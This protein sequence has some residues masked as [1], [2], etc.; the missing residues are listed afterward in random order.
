MSEF[1]MSTNYVHR[2]FKLPTSHFNHHWPNIRNHFNHSPGVPKSKK[3]NQKNIV[4]ATC[5][6]EL[7]KAF[8]CLAFTW[9]ELGTLFSAEKRNEM[10]PML[11]YRWYL[12]M[13]QKSH[14]QSPVGCIKTIMTHSNSTNLLGQQPSDSKKRHSK[15]M[16]NPYDSYPPAPSSSNF[17]VALVKSQLSGS[18]NCRCNSSAWPAAGIWAQGRFRKTIHKFHKRHFLLKGK[19]WNKYGPWPPTCFFVD[20]LAIK[21]VILKR[22]VVFLIMRPWDAP[23]QQPHPEHENTTIGS[24]NKTPSLKLTVRHRKSLIFPGKYHQ[25]WWM[26]LWLFEF[27]GG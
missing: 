17:E 16:S 20:S 3:T 8:R 5:M 12:L 24:L 27:S 1:S 15:S 11:N 2:I 9:R 13:V 6:D 25:K 18:S 7:L 4:L 23:I 22:F 10:L 14:S 21:K 19:L 26:F